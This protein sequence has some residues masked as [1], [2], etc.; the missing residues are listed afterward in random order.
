MDWFL[1][2]SPFTDVPTDFA[3]LKFRLL[4]SKNAGPSYGKKKHTES[5]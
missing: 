1:G 4:D 3:F 2:K 5:K